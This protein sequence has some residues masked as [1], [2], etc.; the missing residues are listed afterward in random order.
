M[1][2]TI[3]DKQMTKLTPE[4]I[5]SSLNQFT[6][7]EQFHKFSVL[8]PRH[9]LSDGVKWLAENLDCYWLCDLVASYHGRCMKDPKNML[10][11]MQFWTLTVHPPE[12]RISRNGNPK[13]M[14]KVICERDTGDV[15]FKQKIPYTDFP[16]TSIK[17]YCAPSGDGVHYTIYLPSEH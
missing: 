5:K 17:L 3:G 10:Q 11:G 16:L 8:F 2:L 6:G 4:E 12:E 7:S 9:V 15:A 1:I 13:P 14:A